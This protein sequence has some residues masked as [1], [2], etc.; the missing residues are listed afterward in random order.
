MTH[1]DGPF[2]PRVHT[3]FGAGQVGRKLAEL[4]LARGHTVR[5]VQRSRA[6]LPWPGLSWVIG[7]ATDRAFARRA[8]AG[9]DVVYNCANPAAYHRWRELLLPLAR[10][11]RE[12]AGHGGSRLVVLDNVYM[13]G[14]PTKEPFCEATPHRPCSDNGALRAE[15]ADELFAAHRRGD[16]QAVSGRASDYFGPDSPNAAAFFPRVFQRIAAGKAVEV[17]GNPDT[18]HSY[19][20]TPDVAAGLATLG[21][22]PG[23][24]G[25]PWHLPVAW[26]G[27]TRELMARFAD[28]AGQ[29]LRVRR[30]PQWLLRSVGVAVPLA[31]AIADAVYQ[32]DADIVV[33]DRAFRERF[34]Q[35]ATPIEEAVAV[36]ARWGFS[37]TTV[38]ERLASR[39]AQ[40]A[41]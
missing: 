21:A 32:W 13:Y 40:V 34:G 20:Y 33:D 16:V 41:V 3:I 9:A 14:A 12:A 35:F 17:I 19:S 37:G 39:A 31:R 38:G 27:T 7:D 23:G 10:S 2:A 15:L 26:Q 29:P 22:D 28:V 4:L 11:I 24:D 25:L 6:G 1:R 36:T 30:V 8:C 18:V 5:L